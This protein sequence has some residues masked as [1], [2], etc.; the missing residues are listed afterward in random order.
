MAAVG[1]GSFSVDH[2]PLASAQ[3]SDD[4]VRLGTAPAKLPKV[5]I[6]LPRAPTAHACAANLQASALPCVKA[7][8]RELGSV[9]V[10]SCFASNVAAVVLFG[11]ICM[12][13]H[14]GAMSS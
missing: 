11:E 5:A 1:L 3:P 2:H 4:R 6:L 12:R 10:K 7:A 8:V 9:D 13:A 14:M